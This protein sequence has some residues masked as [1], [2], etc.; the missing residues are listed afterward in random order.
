[1]IKFGKKW[2]DGS[3]FYFYI[4]GYS[5]IR[6]FI[7]G[8]RIDSAQDF[9]GLRLNQWTSIFIFILGLFLFYRNQGKKQALS[10]PE[11]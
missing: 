1:L 8:L 10:S 3:V 6:F 9:A 11:I 5:F 4:T 2:R 7:E